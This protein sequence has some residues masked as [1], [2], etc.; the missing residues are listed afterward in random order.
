LPDGFIGLIMAGIAD[1]P[2]RRLLI[3]DLGSFVP[4]AACADRRLSPV[5]PKGLSTLDTADAYFRDILTPFGAPTDA[6]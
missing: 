4:W 2:I 5:A 3:N 6:Q 1:S